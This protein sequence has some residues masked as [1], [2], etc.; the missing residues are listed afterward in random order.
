MNYYHLAPKNFEN[1]F[2]VVLNAF[3]YEIIMKRT[4]FF[5]RAINNFEEK[6]VF[7]DIHLVDDFTLLQL[8][9]AK[10]L[11]RMKKT[12]LKIFLRKLATQ[13]ANKYYV[14]CTM[15]YGLCHYGVP[16]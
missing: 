7:H 4:D 9:Q 14:A 10:L 8:I 15:Y 16:T 3:L 6:I 5:F 12:K 11:V 2:P 1:V 13:F